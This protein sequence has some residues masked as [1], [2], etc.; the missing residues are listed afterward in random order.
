MST[1]PPAATL[2]NPT[3]RAVLL[4]GVMLLTSAGATLAMPKP[5]VTSASQIPDVEGLLP[6][7]FGRWD[8]DRTIVPLAVSPDLQQMLATLYDRTVSR[9]YVN[10]KG[11]RV[12][13]SV[14]YGANQSRALQLHKPEVCYAAQ[15]F[16]ISTVQKGNWA[17]GGV[18]I[19]TMHLVGKLGPRNEPVTYWMRVGD[20]IARG[21]LEQN[22]VRLKYGTRGYI[23]DGVLFRLSSISPDSPAA[24][25]LQRQ[26]VDEMMAAM[27]PQARTFFVGST[28]MRTAG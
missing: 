13:V 5:Q 22:A 15:G 3:R 10:E 21:W 9:T 24:F 12:M 6:Q 1:K 8:I 20:D 25:E 27:T 2:P 23:P 28:V 19:P 18:N 16:R 26:F 17:A 14:A 11:E 4:G 7:R